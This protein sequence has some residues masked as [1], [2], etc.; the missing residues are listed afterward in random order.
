ML[1]LMHEVNRRGKPSCRASAKLRL[2]RAFNPSRSS[3][4]FSTD[5][6]EIADK[7][8]RQLT[9]RIREDFGTDALDAEDY[10]APTIV[11]TAS[12]VSVTDGVSC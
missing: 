8:S 1:S 3:I 4:A 7:I 10:V 2:P 11:N 6:R 12:L 9:A 5:F